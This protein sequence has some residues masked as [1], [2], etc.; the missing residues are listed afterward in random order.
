[1]SCIQPMFH[2]IVK[3]SPFR[4]VGFDTPG[5]A[6]DSSAIVTAP[7]ILCATSLNVRSS[8]MASRFSFP[9]YWFGIHSPALRE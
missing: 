4:Y 1:M 8:D 2:F 7:S 3:P 5:N 9:P 6:V